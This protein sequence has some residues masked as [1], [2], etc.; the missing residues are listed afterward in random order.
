MDACLDE[1]LLSEGE[2]DF[3]HNLVVTDILDEGGEVTGTAMIRAELVSVVFSYLMVIAAIDSSD[4][5]KSDVGLQRVRQKVESRI[6]IFIR[7]RSLSTTLA[8]KIRLK[9]RRERERRYGV[10]W[11]N[12]SWGVCEQ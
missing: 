9:V 8:A 12:A 2:I 1:I 11:D 5:Y 7:D 4:E 6:N 10:K 3:S